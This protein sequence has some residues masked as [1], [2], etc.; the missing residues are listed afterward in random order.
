VSYAQRC[1]INSLL[2]AKVSIPQIAK[3]INF[4]KSTIY[5]EISR[6]KTTATRKYEPE[7]VYV[8]DT[9]HKLAINR[10]KRCRK[11]LKVV[12]SNETLVTSML[13]NFFSPEQI[14]GRIKL[15]KDIS[16][17][18]QSI[19]NYIRARSHLTKYLRYQGIRNYR[20]RRGK[21]E[22]YNDGLINIKERPED[23]NNRIVFGHW[24]RDLMYAK[25]RQPVF[26]CVERKSR[27]TKL[28]KIQS[29]TFNEVTTATNEVLASVGKKVLSMTNDNGLEFRII[30]AFKFPTYYCD[31]YKPWQRGTVENTI[32]VI[33]RFITNKTDL[34]TINLTEI[35]NWLNMRPRKVLDYLTPYEVLFK[36][37]VALAI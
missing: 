35:E 9:A 26:V 8:A 7:F 29:A 13:R 24:E 15:E 36:T 22:I 3:L 11:K 1:Q 12:G 33:R 37:K 20:Y 10:F 14:S 19:Y 4:N 31:P 6:N 34:S 17:S 18:H 21:K 5:R 30:Q 25:E 27:F 2:Q 28:K 23:A 32:G 16:L